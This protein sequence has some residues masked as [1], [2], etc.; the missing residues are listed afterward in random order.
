MLFAGREYRA[1]FIST[2]EVTAE[3]G[4]T[5]DP[6]KSICD[7]YVFNTVI[8]RAQSLIVC[9]GNPFLLF[10]IEKHTPNYKINCWREYVKRCL[11][12]SSFQLVP[13]CHS[14]GE[15]VLQQSIA[16]LYE[17]T[18]GDLQ[19]SLEAP[20]GNV[21]KVSDSILA[22]YKRAFQSNKAC[23]DVKLI[24]GNIGN[25]DRGYVL[26]KGNRKRT[27][28]R[29][30]QASSTQG[31]PVECYLESNT[32]RKAIATPLD[33]SQPAITI[34]GVDN[35]RGALDGSLVKVTLYK[36]ADRCGQV[37]EI[38]EQGP[39]QQFV[40]SVDSYNSIFFCP[41]DRKSPKLVN[42]P[43]LSREMLKQVSNDLIIRQE[44]SYKQHAVTVFDPK[45]FT[46]PNKEA[47]NG[48]VK[49]AN[50]EIPQIKDVIPLSI[51]QKLLFVVLFLRWNAKYRYPLGVVIAAIPRGLTLYHAQRML[52]AHHCINTSSVD[53]APDDDDISVVAS[54]DS[55][56]PLYDHAMTIDPLEA[57]ILD[58]ALT[59]EPLPNED[60]GQS[61][62]L[63]VHIAN[64]GRFL[65]KTSVA[66]KN[67]RKRGTAVYGSKSIQL[68]YPML[69]MELRKKLTI[70]NNKNTSSTISITC[71]V[72]VVDNN[73]N[74]S[75][76][77]VH[78]SC[79]FSR[80]RLTYDDAQN[81]LHGVKNSRLDNLVKD[82]NTTLVTN[83]TFGLKQRLAVLL[84][85][86]EFFFKD[87]THSDSVNY[88]IEDDEVLLSPQAH[89]LVEEM[90]IWAN[91]IAAEHVLAAFP[92]LTVLRRQKP[93]N[94]D[95]LKK[96]LQ[97]YKDAVNYSPVFKSH[98]SNLNTTS[99]LMAELFRKH[100]LGALQ[101]TPVNIK[102]ASNLFRVTSYHPQLAVLSKEVNSS[103]WRAQYVCTGN[104]QKQVKLEIQ[105]GD[106]LVSLTDAQK[107][108]YGHYDQCCLYTHFTS[109]LRRYI[110]IV[111]Q[112][113]IL[114]SFSSS[115]DLYTED[116]LKSICAECNART[117]SA[118]NFEREFNRLTL[119]LSL[120]ECSQP[121]T[122]YVASVE[123]SL[124]LVIRELKYQ[125]LSL[126][127]R[128]FHLSS[129]TNGATPYYTAKPR[130]HLPDTDGSSASKVNNSKSFIWK[131]KTT[132]FTPNYK[133]EMDKLT[134]VKKCLA[135][136]ILTQD[137]MLTFYSPDSKADGS[138]S[139]AEKLFT[140]L[141]QKCYSAKFI[142]KVLLLSA[143]KWTT[144]AT[145]MKQPS[146]DTAKPL[147]EL[148]MSHNS[149]ENNNGVKFPTN[150]SFWLYEVKQ[151]FEAY[152]CFKISLAANF[153]DYILSPCIQ[154]LEVAPMLNVCVQHCTNP[155]SCFSTPI[156]SH[157]SRVQYNDIN[158]YID[159]W[160]KVLLAEA[161]VQSVNDDAEVKLIQNVPL[162]WPKLVQPI[163][164][165]DSIHYLPTAIKQGASSG[166]DCGVTLDIH[167][168]FIERC[169]EYFDIQVGNLVCA[170]Y[171]IPLSEPK[172]V[173]GRNV[174]TASA[175]YHFVI[176]RIDEN[177]D[178]SVATKSRKRTD[179]KSVKQPKFT[180]HL[181]I[182]SKEAGRVSKFMKPYLENPNNLC[183]IQIIPLDT[184]YRYMVL[185]D[186]I[187]L[188]F[189]IY[190]I[191]MH[192]RMYRS[193]LSLRN[194]TDSGVSLAEKIALGK[195]FNNKICK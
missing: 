132:S 143:E 193:L 170:R 161:A 165:L 40:C 5:L 29:P 74:I 189:T 10:S 30:V 118:N 151:S 61:Y 102:R 24:L 155:A 181:K 136:S 116:E 72:S 64:V 47:G 128:S 43:G 71:N 169:G 75:D 146:E 54:N 53:T 49:F 9:V 176:D 85:I 45:S 168:D 34:N 3:D 191:Y 156:L 162:K 69:P 18:F 50:V 188:S 113:L 194:I 76:I 178:Q 123:K 88:T 48:S 100:L 79:V 158:E 110:D 142:N 154:L 23:Q 160:E 94:Q 20:C 52:L 134:G 174:E 182:V 163:N 82:F 12:T 171:N 59:L 58:D 107:E 22:A 145:F 148:L 101:S 108:V 105:P 44:L 1:I 42:L 147:K 111:M 60:D 114:Q 67:A 46:N 144:V 96:A 121:C 33:P 124:Q 91:R 32:F 39:Q 126:D 65:S 179:K 28:D 157:A 68:F 131:V 152:K 164:S 78:E 129:V 149:T 25:G 35:R 109:P 55:L 92:K 186:T 19:E 17:E 26:Q 14:I 187:L 172:T 7:Q 177:K 97:Q 130:Q 133:I 98:A 13:E 150:A 119:A 56:L 112:R 183:E 8:T 4:S 15:S 153:S 173:E 11:E 77:K 80:A 37:V 192:R 137:A 81:L 125:F 84:Q 166:Q 63:G 115:N 66:D 2:L 62:Q 140:P 180:V 90:M 95:Q 104:F 190:D 73:I 93:P 120:A 38:V 106:Y 103:K 51:A 195:P 184:P 185:I 21:Q 127:Q 86:S 6:T 159:L 175:V 70:D 89:F 141:T 117:L 167:D 135:N 41:I 36:D 31:T 99:F 138:A 16:K 122:A 83:N 87:R 139:S 57:E 27:A